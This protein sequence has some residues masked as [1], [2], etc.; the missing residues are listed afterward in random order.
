MCSRADYTWHA[1]AV[2]GELRL[3]EKN[4]RL[5]VD[6]W[7]RKKITPCI[8][9]GVGDSTEVVSKTSMVFL[10]VGELVDVP[11]AGADAVDRILGPVQAERSSSI[12]RSSTSTQ[13]ISARGKWNGSL[14][15]R[16]T[17]SRIGLPSRPR[18]CVH[19]P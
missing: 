18:F 17:V 9:A 1:S 2:K 13:Q 8:E 12:N 15:G 10:H 14:T 11:G 16:Q 5:P 6:A 3:A 7:L 4:T 19:S